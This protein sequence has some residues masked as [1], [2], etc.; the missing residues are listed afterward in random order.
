MFGLV[1]RTPTSPHH[2]P[3]VHFLAHTNEHPGRWWAAVRAQGTGLLPSMWEIWI[4]WL[5]TSPWPSPSHVA[6]FGKLASAC[7]LSLSLSASQ[8]DKI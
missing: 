4:E 7:E 2:S 6:A 5:Q 3:Q 8:T 1:V